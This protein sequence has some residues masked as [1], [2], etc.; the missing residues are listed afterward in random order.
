[1]PYSYLKRKIQTCQAKQDVN[2]TFTALNLANIY[3]QYQRPIHVAT[4]PSPHKE[5]GSDVAGQ[6][7]EWPWIH[8]N[9]LTTEKNLTFDK[10][11]IWPLYPKGTLDISLRMLGYSILVDKP[12][13]DPIEIKSVVPIEFK[14]KLLRF[15]NGSD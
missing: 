10:A 3:E 6:G 14:F 12:N 4:G 5:F 8:C 11:T 1:M 9:T 15:E 2:A 7:V 13:V